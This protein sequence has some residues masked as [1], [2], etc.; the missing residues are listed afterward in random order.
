M[1]NEEAY[2]RAWRAMAR[3]E[4]HSK[5]PFSCVLRKGPNPERLKTRREKVARLVKEGLTTAQIGEA[6]GLSFAQV[7][8]DR[9]AILR[10]A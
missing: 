7:Q 3:A 5:R 1:I 9:H 4:G 6:L 10:W 2:G 8:G